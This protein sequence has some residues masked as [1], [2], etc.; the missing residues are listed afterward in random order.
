MQIRLA[1]ICQPGFQIFCLRLCQSTALRSG[2]RPGMADPALND[3]HPANRLIT[4][5]L[6]DAF[7]DL[8]NFML[9]KQRMGRYNAD[10]QDGGSS[11]SAALVMTFGPLNGLRKSRGFII[12]SDNIR[13]PGQQ[14]GRAESPFGANR[15]QCGTDQIGKRADAFSRLFPC[16]ISSV[17][18]HG[19]RINDICRDCNNF[20]RISVLNEKTLS[21]STA[22]LLLAWYDRHGRELPWRVRPRNGRQ[23]AADPYRVWLSEIMLQQ[24]TVTAVRP[25]YEKFLTLWPT[26]ADLAAADDEAVMVAWAGLGYYSRARNLLKCARVVATQFNGEFPRTAADLQKLPGIGPYTAAAVAAIAFRD[27]AAVVDGNVERVV[28][29][30]LTIE[31]ALPA[32]K[33]QVREALLPVIPVDRPGD[34]AQALMDLGATLCAPKRPACGLCPLQ[35]QCQAFATG[36]QDRFPVKSAKVQKPTRVGAA[37]LLLRQDQQI[38]LQK[39][40]AGGLLAGMTEVP[41]TGW[42]ARQDGLT[43][44]DAAPLAADWESVGTV[45]HTFTHFHLELTVYK[46]EFGIGTTAAGSFNSL[47]RDGW[48]RD[49]ASLQDEA[50]PNLMRK[51]IAQGLQPR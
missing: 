45:R 37:F 23:M 33:Q 27:P 29:R 30:L 4:Q 22:G 42:T 25:Y 3:A 51:V 15:V 35:K 36:T 24:T 31:T 32:A 17:I 13:P 11:I 38:W 1:D 21:P 28:T 39:R 18:D 5:E 43:T 12:R 9:K 2:L 19:H 6:I 26:I 41:T 16:R 40:A 46:A 44:S 7:H 49:L 34:L 50:L 8:R 14:G 47:P 20:I 48:W 10:G